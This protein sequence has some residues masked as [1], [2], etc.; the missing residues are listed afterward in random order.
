[1]IGADL[2]GHSLAHDEAELGGLLVLQQ[3]H[4]ARAMLLPLVH[5]PCRSATASPSCGHPPHGVRSK[6]SRIRL[7]WIG[8]KASLDGNSHVEE[9]ALVLLAIGDGDLL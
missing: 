8:R 7:E 9:H 1:M 6:P 5:C 3:L 2:E 4:G